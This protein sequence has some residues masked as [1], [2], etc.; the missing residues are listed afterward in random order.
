MI[1][2]LTATFIMSLYLA[3][4]VKYF[5][6]PRSLSD[7][8]YLLE[9]KGWIFQVVL[10]LFSVLLMPIWIELSSENTQFLAFL[11]CGGL[12]FVAAAPCFKV[13]IEGKIHYS[14]AVICCLSAFIWQ[15]IEMCWLIP[16]IS[17]S[18][19]LIT[20]AFFKGKLFWWIEMGILIS[21]VISIFIKL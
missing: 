20:T 18:C 8:Y 1:A 2:L 15:I 9:N 14:S 13:K 12:M 10:G 19:A 5:G 4:V 11:A 6:I 21:S 16:V 17:L 3:Y 7:T